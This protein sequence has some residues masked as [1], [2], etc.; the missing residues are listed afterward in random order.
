MENDISNDLIVKVKETFKKLFNSNP[1]IK[2]YN[3]LLFSRKAT[4]KEAHAFSVEVGELL[5]QAFK[6]HITLEAL[7]EGRMIFSI[8]DQVLRETIGH[9]FELI[10]EY[11]K[12]VQEILNKKAGIGIKA[13][14]ATV[15]HKNLENIINRI[16]VEDDFNEVVWIL[17]EPVVRLGQMIV[18]ETVRANA[19]FHFK[20]GLRPKIVRTSKGDCCEWCNKLAGTYEYSEVSNTGNDV[21]RRHNRCRCLVEYDPRNG[22]KKVNVHTH[23]ETGSKEDI[24][25]RVKQAKKKEAEERLARE[26][27]KQERISKYKK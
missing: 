6:E 16:A 11:S 18:D 12:V 10:S 25:M 8:A 21:Y 14:K 4:Y 5:A 23:K 9:H 20:S 27:R 13:I 7:P 26:K 3:D 22:A 19:D 15:D 24:E 1:E 2:K 17:Q